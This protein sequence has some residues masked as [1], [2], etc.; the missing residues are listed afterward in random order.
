MSNRR[1]RGILL[2]A[3]SCGA[4][5]V[6]PTPAAAD[7]PGLLIAPSPFD[8]G[9]VQ[10]GSKSAE[11]VFVVKNEGSEP[12]AIET[13]ALSGADAGQ[14][15]ISAGADTCS[16]MDLPAGGEAGCN[17]GVVF[18]PTSAGPKS[19]TLQVPTNAAEPPATVALSGIGASPSSPPS[20]GGSG[21]PPAQAVAPARPS[22]AFGFGKVV[23]N[24]GRG[25]ASL[26]VRVPG[27]GT[28]LLGGK[29]LIAR[30]GPGSTL[31]LGG[32]GTARLAIVATGRW[33]SALD[34]TG[35]AKVVASVTYTPTGGDALTKSRKIALVKRR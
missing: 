26:P 8:F 35:R 29:G 5:I 11:Q 9:T 12:A 10:P 15:E 17:V 34:R 23:Y 24:R 31:V 1:H 16:S 19:A 14:F 22:N 27:P 2:V 30:K 6:M 25:T 3:L 18:A 28:L 21:Q 7:P 20:G 13:V 32:A 33:E 4:A